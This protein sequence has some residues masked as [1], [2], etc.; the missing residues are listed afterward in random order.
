MEAISVG[1][2]VLFSQPM[3]WIVM[4]FGIFEG[5]IFG[6]IPGLTAVLCVTLM[7]PFTFTMT[8]V[9]GLALLVSIYVGAISGGLITA[10][11]INIPG[12]PSSLI[13]TWDGY[14]MAKKG[15]PAEALS[16]GVFA[17]LL[18]GTFSALVLFGIAPQLAKVALVF[19]SWE[20]FGVCLMG[21][22]IVS[23]TTG[24]DTVKGL[25]GAVIGLVLGT[26]G[27]DALTG[28]QRLTFG[29]WQLQG[30]LNATVIM[31]SFFA[32]REI[33]NQVNGLGHREKTVLKKKISFR[34]P[35]KEMKDCV[36]ALT[37]GSFIGTWVGI[38][39]GIGQT[40]ATI[41]A[42][43]QVKNI[44]KHP[45]E[46]GKGSPEGIAVS[47]SANNACNGGALIP[48]ITLGIPGDGVTIALIGGFMIHGIQP[49][50]LLFTQN[51]DLVGV[52]MVVYFISN[53]VMYFME[54]G[55]MKAF[56]KMVN[57]PY[58]LLFPAIIVFCLLGVFALNNRIYDL[59]ILIAFAIFGYILN[60]FKIDMVS[61]ILG[62]V[63]GP[64]VENHLRRALI[65]SNGSF[66]DIF[67][68]PLAVVFLVV[69]LIFLFW[70]FIKVGVRKI[71]PAKVRVI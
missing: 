20:Y 56:I 48:L 26:V 64:M 45:E 60:E 70:P 59:G 49:G 63:L 58:S 25:L 27:I 28:I 53:F 4:V 67:T 44:S 10:T 14:P 54:L 51:I 11:L 47:E 21:L 31:M 6:A 13:T 3:M 18:G 68:R 8:P 61:L 57:V 36:P 41:L 19:G 2:Q 1:F 29:S 55:M 5:I 15:K 69:S 7:I 33:T 32:I 62:F 43:H 42:Y 52:I 39:P 34:P 16:I 17:S 38:L 65:A 23:S 35:L 40:P 46:F 22:S 30:G 24:E 9:M 71:I 66:N 12:T 37:I 50:P